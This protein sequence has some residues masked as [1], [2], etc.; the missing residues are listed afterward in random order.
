MHS[1]RALPLIA[2]RRARLG[3]FGDEANLAPGSLKCF[4]ISF[5]E[6]VEIVRRLGG[7][8][9]GKLG[10]GRL[11]GVEVAV[12]LLLRDQLAFVGMSSCPVERLGLLGF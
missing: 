5:L 2:K 6:P 12:E 3:I 1:P 10:D 7:V 4:T 9:N 11:L 8:L